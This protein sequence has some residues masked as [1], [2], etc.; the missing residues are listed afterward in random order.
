[1]SQATDITLSAHHLTRRYGSGLA[2]AEL[3]LELRRGE[4]LGLLGPNGAGKSTTMQMLTG[5]LAPSSG[6]IAV[7]G[8]D[9]LEQP[10]QAKAKIGYLPETPPLYRE[11]TVDEFLRFCGRLH[12]ISRADLAQ[13]VQQAK[14]RCGLSD[15]GKHLIA[16][17]SKGYQQR[18]GIAQAIIHQPDVVILD[19][20]TVG[21]DPNQIREIRTLIRELAVQHSVILSTHI[22]PEVEAVCDRVQI[23]HRG[24]IVFADSIDGLRRSQQTEILLLGFARP[25]TLE[26]FIAATGVPTAHMRDNGLFQVPCAADSTLAQAITQAAAANDWG[27]TQ[28]T[29]ER[30]SLEDV[31]AELT[32][33]EQ[34][35]EV[36][37]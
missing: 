31:F 32:R 9:L 26:A 8:I 28:M 30:T 5:N 35:T 18:V 4:V 34:S 22:L 10:K 37:A 33:I 19:E 24:K 12:R 29:P 13:A 36:A 7:C 15:M 23:M 16:H 11:L 3:D 20:P 2:V 27:L 14:A 21:L 1:M 25:P 17:L 6:R